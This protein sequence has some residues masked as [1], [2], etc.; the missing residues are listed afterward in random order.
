MQTRHRGRAQ[1]W[2]GLSQ[3]AQMYSSQDDKFRWKLDQARG[4][5]GEQNE[6]GRASAEGTWPV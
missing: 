4:G 1:F 3:K 2:L 6:P 5:W